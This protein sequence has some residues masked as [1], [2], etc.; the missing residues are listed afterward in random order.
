MVV[1]FLDRLSGLLK[2]CGIQCYAWA[3]LDDHFHLLLRSGAIPRGTVRAR[4]FLCYWAA[5]ELRMCMTGLSAQL[6]ISV[7]CVSHKDKY[8]SNLISAFI[9]MALEFFPR[10]ANRVEKFS[11]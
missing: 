5:G 9:E 7:N 4:G 3:I 11:P 8:I 2:D 10:S 1:V 6:K